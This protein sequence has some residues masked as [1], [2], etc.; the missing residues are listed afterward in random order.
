MCPIPERIQAGRVGE[1][2]AGNAGVS[3]TYS[4]FHAKCVLIICLKKGDSPVVGYSYESSFEI[5]QVSDRYYNLVTVN[6][7]R[8]KG[9]SHC[10][11]G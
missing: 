11:N 1:A 6:P 7:D 3:M 4:P 8:F 9:K 5:I 10:G 2:E